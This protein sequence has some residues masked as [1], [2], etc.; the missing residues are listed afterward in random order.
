[1][2]LGTLLVIIIIYII[3]IVISL[4]LTDFRIKVAYWLII[5][6]GTLTAINIY[7]SISYYISL[8]NEVGVPGP[9]G[10]KG[11]KGPSGD[12]GKCVVSETCGIQNCS[13][14]VYTI[15]SRIYP[16]ITL[17]CMK[18]PATCSDIETREKA[19][20]I[21]K[22]M[23]QLVSECQTTKLPEEDFMRR[24]MPQIEQMKVIGA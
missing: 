4:F 13:D 20:P 15:A 12:I 24:I 22:I 3:L 14:K 11:D 2:N 17:E 19:T 16:D 21:H 9:R 6:L 7:L 18:D 5:A 23:E 8:R 1:M 10:P